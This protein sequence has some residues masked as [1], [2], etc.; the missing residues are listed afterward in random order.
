MFDI[1]TILVVSIAFAMVLLPVVVGL[2]LVFRFC[3]SSQP[4]PKRGATRMTAQEFRQRL[5][6]R[7]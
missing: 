5:R 2:C 3:F 1:F 4:E 6:N 7:V